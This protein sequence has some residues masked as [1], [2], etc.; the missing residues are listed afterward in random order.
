MINCR[1][2]QFL[3]FSNIYWQFCIGHKFIFF[4]TV[5][6]ICFVHYKKSFLELGVSSLEQSST[7]VHGFW[8]SWA[9]APAAS[10]KCWVGVE[11]QQSCHCKLEKQKSDTE[12]LFS[13]VGA[14]WTSLWLCRGTLTALL[15][16]AQDNMKQCMW[17]MSRSKKHLCEH[18]FEKKRETW[19][20]QR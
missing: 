13:T 15:I 2:R 17:L 20:T 5:T 19:L 8:P 14:F 4:T 18:C 7:W 12:A 6:R 16:E 3:L 11:M 10:Q 9:D 1:W